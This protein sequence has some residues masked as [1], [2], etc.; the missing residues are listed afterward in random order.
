[1]WAEMKGETVQ[2]SNSSRLS[3]VEIL[4]NEVIDNVTEEGWNSHI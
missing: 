2:L 4:M 3:S 1:M